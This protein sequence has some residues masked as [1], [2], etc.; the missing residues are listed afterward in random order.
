MWPERELRLLASVAARDAWL[1]LSTS[2]T[3]VEQLRALMD[4][5]GFAKAR[6]SGSSSGAATTAERAFLVDRLGG[7]SPKPSNRDCPSHFRE[8]NS[9]KAQQHVARS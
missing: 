1:L 3:F 7:C 5:L 9:L 4:T 8:P 2:G 6:S